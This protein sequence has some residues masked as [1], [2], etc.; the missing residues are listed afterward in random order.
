ML[1][2]LGWNLGM[3]LLAIFVLLA[4]A[5]VIG[6]ISQFIGRTEVGYEWVLVA[7][8]AVVG[9]WLGSETFGTLSTWGPALD[10]LYLL[11][12]LIGAVVLGALVDG[13]TRVMTG[14]SYL[15]PRPI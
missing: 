3:S 12:A 8:G 10:G 2:L 15:E 6:V 11:P 4:G 13:A 1:E 9:G 5:A 7:I 14:G